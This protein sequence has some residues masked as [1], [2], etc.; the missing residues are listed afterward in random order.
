MN[1][2]A[3]QTISAVC[4]IASTFIAVVATV[5]C[6]KISQ[7]VSQLETRIVTRLAE[8]YVT[9]DDLQMVLTQGHQPQRK[10]AHA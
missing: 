10:T 5:V 8:Q 3:L 1:L 4:T 9:K 2:G 7:Q 6:L